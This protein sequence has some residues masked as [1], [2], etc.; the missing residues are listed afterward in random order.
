MEFWGIEVKPERTLMVEPED[1]YLIHV[2]QITI[3]DLNKLEEDENVPVYVKHGE[4]KNAFVIGNLSKKCPQVS[5]DIFFGQKFVISH[6]SESSV[7][8]IGYKSPDN[9]EQDEEIDS[10]SELEEYMEQQCGVLPPNEMNNE[11]N[12]EEDESDS[13]EE[14]DES[15][16][17][18]MGSDEDED[19]SDEEDVEDEAPLKVEPPSKK[20]PNGKATNNTVASKKAKAA[21]QNKSSGGKKKCPFP[22][23]SSCKN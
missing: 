16:S 13:G 18:E 15:G 5:L 21:F 19:E 10:D 23:G 9:D 11:I 12:P 17:D 2:S 3:G 4:D 1:G 22:C 20:I 8:L 6:S 14:D 7:F